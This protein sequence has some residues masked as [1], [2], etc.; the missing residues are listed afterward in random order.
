MEKPTGRTKDD[1]CFPVVCFLLP[2]K[3]GPFLFGIHTLAGRDAALEKFIDIK[4][5]QK[6]TTPNVSS[7]NRWNK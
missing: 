1:I 2:V 5:K 7:G 6:V 4:W 3:L